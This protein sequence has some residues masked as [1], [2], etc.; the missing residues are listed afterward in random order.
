MKTQQPI[1]RKLLGCQRRLSILT[2]VFAV[3][4]AMSLPAFGAT[5]HVDFADGNNQ[6][7][8]L[9]PQTA[10][11]HSP[12]DRNAKDK[13]AAAKLEP[14]D[15]ILFKGGVAYHGEIQMSASGSEGKPITLDGNS[16]GTFGKGRAIL[17]G[18][19]MI[20]NWRRVGSSAEVQGN[21]KWN[22]IVYAD[23]DVDLTSNFN[24]DR[25]VAHRDAGA[26][27]QAPWQRLFLI[28]GERRILP[29]AQEPKP[30]D[31]FYPDIPSD[32]TQSP[33]PLANDYPHRVYYEEGTV[34][35]RS[36]PVMGITFGGAAPVIQPFNGGAVSVEMKQPATISE[37]GFTLHRPA[38]TPV[39]EHIVFLADGKEI[40]KAEVDPKQTAM[41]RFKF[42]EPVKA[43]K[44]TFQLRHSNPGKQ[45][46]TKLEQIAAFTPEGTN[47]IQHRISSIIRDEKRLVQK[48]ANWYDGMFVGVHGG[49]NHVYFAR[50]R[51]YDPETHQLLVPHF[52]ATTYNTTRY[53]L[54]NSPRFIERPGEWCL[55]PLEGGRTRVYLLPERLQDGQP[56]NIGYPVLGTGILLNGPASH[57]QVRGFLIQRYTGGAGAVATRQQK[58]RP[59][60]IAI[61]DCEVRF[62]SG[63]SGISLNHS[64]HVA[65]ENCFVHQ[66][67]GWTVGIY[68]NR[69]TNFR[70]SGNRL[71]K[72]SGSGIRHYEAKHGVLRENVVLNHFGMHS[73]GLNFYEGSSDI[74]FE[75][76]YVHNT[77]A[78][79]RNA[80]RITFRNNVIDGLGKAPVSVGMWTSGTL[81]G[82][83][84][85]DI[86][87]IN[88]T[89]VNSDPKLTWAT[90][91]LGQRAGSPG[92][93]QG[94]IIRNNILH[95]LAEDISGKIE[96]NIY[97][98]EV[99]KRF[100]GPGSQVISDLELLFRDPARGDF[101]RKPGGP[102][103]DVGATV[104]PPAGLLTQKG[105]N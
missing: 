5:Y 73:S 90:G 101:R 52:Q 47:V 83:E 70:L 77:I 17:D 27:Q 9:T 99:E 14:G 50:V 75:G 16:A 44:L 97:T 89:F 76:N 32:F 80:E 53:A 74:V 13:P 105:T 7:D 58:G 92:A 78:I 49:N 54:Y 60:H 35:N 2:P 24:Q 57:I 72:N 28:D 102:A 64:D 98:R 33:H 103:M 1:G 20:T 23:L 96:N 82:R 8:G 36:L 79:N 18:A 100:M 48:E 62:I 31:P 86:H 41:Q 63:Q 95:G 19:R 21:S 69:T 88:N 51:R 91:I 6:S 71:D 22:Q 93:P 94:L 37:M 56:V 10:W 39:P 104:A 84:I 25:F 26:A 38:I 46:W 87:F 68:V 59:S 30:S 81:G 4:M 11:K 3:F 12:G 45:T 43:Q 29:I 15:T 55:A 85:K 40:Y 65:V 42:P 34:G 61:S 67:P 66:C